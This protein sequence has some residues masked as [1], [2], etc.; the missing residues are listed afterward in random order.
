[1]GGWAVVRNASESGAS[2]AQGARLVMIHL[3][4]KWHAVLD[5]A[6]DIFTWTEPAELA[7]LAEQASK[8]W[9]V[10]EVGSYMGH[11]AK[12]LA[13]AC[14]GTVYAVDPFEVAG[15]RKVFEYF[16]RDELRSGH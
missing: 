13:A 7:S 12:V 16:L 1:M 11:S 3:Q 5:S 15:T 9:V 2:M 4:D 10:V 6:R 14:Q 8:C